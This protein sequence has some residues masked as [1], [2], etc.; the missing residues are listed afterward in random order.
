MLGQDREA[1]NEREQMGREDVFVSF[2]MSS[3]G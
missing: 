3:G 2:L 1:Y